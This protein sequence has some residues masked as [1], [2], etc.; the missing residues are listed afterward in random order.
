MKP[1][2]RL[3]EKR[4]GK[5]MLCFLMIMVSI[6]NIIAVIPTKA[7]APSFSSSLGTN[8]ALGSPLVEQTFTKEDW[9]KWEMLTF[10]IFL[11]N[12][13]TPFIDSYRTAFSSGYGG[14]EGSGK[15]ALVFAAGGDVNSESIVS[16]MLGYCINLQQDISKI[17]E[18]KV[19]YSFYNYNKIDSDRT[20]AFAS[21]TATLRDILVMVLPDTFRGS[22]YADGDFPYV[23]T[24]KG[25]AA[26]R[27]GG[28]T[29]EKYFKI[30]SSTSGTNDYGF[31]YAKEAALSRLFF[32]NNGKEIT[33]FDMS[34][35][36]DIQILS[37][38]LAAVIESCN[39][40]KEV[41]DILENLKNYN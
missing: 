16:T 34:D 5:S 32:D 7:A 31:E 18:L 35:G 20:D 41:I 26:G 2:T 13:A 6:I 19:D 39:N 8:K 21:K 3:K 38:L 27:Y 1:F 22:N 9:N 25:Q 28:Y 15:R 24:N 23:I 14:S 33:L 37:A 12:F 40:D 17:K 4:I 11:S 29:A 30:K 36:Y 10:G